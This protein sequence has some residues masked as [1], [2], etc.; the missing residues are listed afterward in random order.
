M[1]SGAAPSADELVGAWQLVS[2]GAQPPP[3]EPV[4]V[5]R[6]GHALVLGTCEHALT[7]HPAAD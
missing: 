4:P 3:A 1:N 2:V 7:L 6:D 5:R